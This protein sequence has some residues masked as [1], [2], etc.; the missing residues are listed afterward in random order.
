MQAKNYFPFPVEE[1][2]LDFEIIGEV[3][4][5]GIKKYRLLL[6]A[7]PKKTV[8]Q[9]LSWL[10]KAGIKPASFMTASLALVKFAQA[11]YALKDKVVAVLEM[12]QRFADLGIFSGKELVFV[13]KIPVAG[14]DF[15]QA[16]TT[17][18]LSDKG[19]TEL[20]LEEAERIK[21]KIGIP[22]SGDNTTI[23]D[24]I[25]SVQVLSML[26]SPLEHLIAE[27]ERCFDY[28]REESAGARVDSL[29]L[30]GGASI[31][32]GLPGFL[33]RELGIQVK[34]GNPLEGSKAEVSNPQ[35]FSIAVGAALSEGKGINLLPPEIKEVTRR[36]FKR[37]A[38]EVTVVCAILLSAFLYTGMKISVNNYQKRIAVTQ[39]E[40]A[41]LK[42]QMQQ[43]EMVALLSSEPYWEGVFKEL[44]NIVPPGIY[45][46]RLKMENNVLYLSGVSEGQDADKTI[47]DLIH[48]LEK[49]L[50]MQVRL[51]S[52]RGAQGKSAKEFELTFRPE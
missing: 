52:S 43:V 24:K 9:Y 40:L 41:S 33:S 18:L 12:G 44:S 6:A 35:Q 15:T 36:T 26:R 42:P 21:C 31:L 34:L 48:G 38:I 19:R 17:A 50:F 49:G 4:E 51:V 2:M 47:S 16:L 32:G 39:K 13:R 37:T 20:S 29:V 45:L 25:S 27:I 30:L 22:A 23:E 5:K 14:A 8:Q 11:H 46:T 1:A 28:Y 3:V 7:A 10:T